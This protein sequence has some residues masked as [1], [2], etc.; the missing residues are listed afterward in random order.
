MGQAKCQTREEVHTA[1]AQGR[2]ASSPVG[3]NQ[4]KLPGGGAFAL[5]LTEWKGFSSGHGRESRKGGEKGR[6]EG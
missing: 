3:V 5:G 6:L 4:G 2:K 1:A